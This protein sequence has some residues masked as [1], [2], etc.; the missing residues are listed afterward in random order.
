M[1][2][3][4]WYRKEVLAYCLLKRWSRKFEW[5][6]HGTQFCSERSDAENEFPWHTSQLIVACNAAVH[7]E[8]GNVRKFCNDHLQKSKPGLIVELGSILQKIKM[9]KNFRQYALLKLY[10]DSITNVDLRFNLFSESFLERMFHLSTDPSSFSDWFNNFES[11]KIEFKR[12]SIHIW[13]QLIWLLPIASFSRKH[14]LK[15]IKEFSDHCSLW[16]RMKMK[17]K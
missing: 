2:S 17:L 6:I 3:G 13:K 7:C 10:A 15:V 14:V 8:S 12:L 16:V 9:L 1:Y 11:T 5:V 4:F